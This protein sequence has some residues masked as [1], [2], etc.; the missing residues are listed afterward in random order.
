MSQP[1]CLRWLGFCR[2]LN[3][4]FVPMSCHSL[5]CCLGKR[6]ECK[7]KRGQQQRAASE[8]VTHANHHLAR[9][10]R[11][12]ASSDRKDSWQTHSQI[13]SC[14]FQMRSLASESLSCPSAIQHS[15]NSVHGLLT[16]IWL[17]LL[18]TKH[19][20]QLCPLSTLPSPVLSAQAVLSSGTPT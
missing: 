9:R 17:G 12:S 4:L 7:Q 13:H 15:G 10:G 8:P 19:Q 6:K 3:W 5:L 2:S 20:L 11:S 14:G 1:S 18:P 16:E